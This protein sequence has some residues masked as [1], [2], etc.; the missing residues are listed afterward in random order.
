MK[1]VLFL[2]FAISIAA[3][4]SCN[5][6]SVVP[7]EP[8]SEQ[9][10]INA[11]VDAELITKADYEVSGSTA[12]FSWESGD[13][14][15][16][17]VRSY[18]GVNYGSY[19]YYTY[20]YQSGPGNE[21]VFTGDPVGSGYE[22]SG[23]AL[24]PAAV[25]AYTYTVNA[26]D[27]QLIIGNS[28]TYT[29]AHPL[30]NIVPLFGELTGSTYS[31]KPLMGVIAIP[32][33]NIPNTA[34]SIVLS[35]TNGGLSGKSSRFDDGSN[36]TATVNYKETIKN[37]LGGESKGLRRGWLTGT[38]KTLNFE[39]GCFTSQGDAATFYFPI[40]SSFNS[41]G[42][43]TP[44]DNF[45]ITVKQGEST[46][47][48]VSASGLSIAIDRA[49][50]VSLPSIDLSRFTNNAVVAISAEDA[51][52]VKA[53]VSSTK[54]TVTSVRVAGI[55]TNSKAAL[56]TAIP[57]NTSGTEVIG[58]TDEASAVPIL[59]ELASG[60]Y[61]VGYKAFKDDTEL[62]SYILP[63]PF[64]YLCPTDVAAYIGQSS[65]GCSS[66]SISIPDEAKTLTLATSDNPA[67]GNVMLTEFLGIHSN[68]S[69]NDPAILTYSIN[70]TEPAITTISGNGSPIYGTL[71]GTKITFVDVLNQPLAKDR[72]G[73][74]VFLH[75]YYFNQANL[76]FTL[77]GTHTLSSDA[78]TISVAYGNTYPSNGFQNYL[79]ISELYA[80]KL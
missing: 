78:G 53:Y 64:Y 27:F 63:S 6:E 37:Y 75:N 9:V 8:T 41:S 29:P 15:R 57:N 56:D 2:A 19:N 61:Y 46:L 58:A 11:V 67:K 34:T 22:D 54:G 76:A 40:A 72:F 32:V 4:F 33:T 47:A 23:I 28:S 31:F 65:V 16:R 55:A 36:S 3:V 50:I 51:A 77:G 62:F 1:K 26:S 43:S 49:E 20:I 60:K 39:A 25:V 12:A 14:F 7:N 10:T 5:K 79:W 59:G 45:T 35:S 74:N 24:T 80:D 71:V 13:S 52:N 48:T 17:V 44:Y 21:A 69:L 38:N 68:A 30:K 66:S 18:N 42:T 70:G 73:D